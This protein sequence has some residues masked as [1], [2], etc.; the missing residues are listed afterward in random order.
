M[1]YA[2]ATELHHEEYWFRAESPIQAASELDLVQ[3]MQ[4][5]HASLDPR[6]VFACYGKIIGQ[7]LPIK[8]LRLYI[9]DQ[10]FTLGRNNGIELVR[11]IN[12]EQNSYKVHYFLTL[13]LTPTQTTQLAQ[14]ESIVL[15][16]FYNAMKYQ[17][18]ANQAMFDELTGLGN[19]YYFKK[20]IN[21]S[22]ARAKRQQGKVSLIVLDLDKFK[23]LNDTFGHIIGDEVLCAFSNLI[24]DSIRD[25]DQ[26]FRIGG[27]EF[28]IVTEGDAD[29]ASL[30]CN[31]IINQLP[32]QPELTVYNVKCSLG[33]AESSENDL[34]KSLYSR[35]DHAMY[36]AKA[37]GRNCFKVAEN[38]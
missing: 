11:E 37:A 19:R 38:S 28:V 20:C 24:N 9:D 26:A 4:Q 17:K 10:K 23:Q 34:L 16:A 27:D 1:D 36:C 21:K 3:V 2:I 7:Y 12:T 14:L 15:P 30:V 22:L 32:L 13:P 5:F 29:A 33:V 25:T 6:T 35:A 18:M 8:S 31:R